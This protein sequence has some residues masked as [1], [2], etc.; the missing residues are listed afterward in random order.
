MPVADMAD[1]DLAG[2]IEVLLRAEWEDAAVRV[3]DLHRLS[4]GASRETWAFDVTR[5]DGARWPLILRR[6]P[7]GTDRPGGMAN[8][9]AALIAA[10]RAGIPEPELFVHGDDGQALG[11]PFMIME[12]LEGE[13]IPRR[14]LREAQYEAARR[15]FA[16]QCGEILARIHAISADQIPGLQPI[17]PLATCAETLAGLDEPHPVLELGLRWLLVNPPEVRRANTVVHGDF[18][19]GNLIIGEE[20]IRGVLDW[21]VVHL[22][23]PAEDL[24]WLCVNA[25]RFGA[26]P[27]VGGLGSYDELLEGYAAGGG[28]EIG[29]DTV[30]WWETLGTLR[31][32]LGCIA[33][34]RR[35]L[36]G[37]VRS[38]ELA[39]IGRRACEQE[40]DLLELIR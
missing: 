32:G 33:Q 36:D 3:H 15:R 7:P 20:G 9:A 25:W 35:H 28:P 30:R 39:A 26:G 31:W 19:N 40:W 17:D 11:S 10:R 24:G 5:S 23:D 27:P 37:S 8:E 21:E 38:V 14:I 16:F 13:T 12:R 1:S 6:D 2:G 29:V 34:A 18:R 4:G 22:G